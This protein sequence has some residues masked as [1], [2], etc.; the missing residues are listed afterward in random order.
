MHRFGYFLLALVIAILLFILVH[1]RLA[2]AGERVHLYHHYDNYS[3]GVTYYSP[4]SPKLEHPCFPYG[5]GG[6]GPTVTNP[7]PRKPSEKP[8]CI[9]D[10]TGTLTYEREGKY[11]PYKYTDANQ[12]RVERRRQEWLKSRR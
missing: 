8:A 2:N 9:Y 6:I 10:A 7:S 11:C 5:C 3:G 12:Q 1:V 4:Y